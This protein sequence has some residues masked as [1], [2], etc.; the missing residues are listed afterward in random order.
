MMETAMYV[1]RWWCARTGFDGGASPPMPRD[2]A[3]A[4]MDDQNR[5]LYPDIVHWIEPEQE[6]SLK[7]T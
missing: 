1:L 4:W 2:L 5:R 3:Q 7:E 6:R